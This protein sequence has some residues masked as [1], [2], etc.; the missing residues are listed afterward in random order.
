[1]P[2]PDVQMPHAFSSA[3]GVAVQ[4]SWWKCV[5]VLW[6]CKYRALLSDG[7]PGWCKTRGKELCLDTSAFSES[8]PAPPLVFTL[9][10]VLCLLFTRLISP[11]EWE[12]SIWIL[13]LIDKHFPFFVNTLF[14]GGCLAYTG[15]A[16]RKDLRFHRPGFQP[17]LYDWLMD[18]KCV[19]ECWISQH[20]GPRR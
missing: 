20:P 6:L 18:D 5:H 11:E 1:M 15:S 2:K 8:H 7:D 19:S 14:S 17:W 13:L 12:H 10:S 9:S 3:D 16:C 4:C